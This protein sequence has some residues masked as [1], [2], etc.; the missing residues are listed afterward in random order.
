MLQKK[1]SFNVGYMNV[2]LRLLS[3]QG[4]INQKIISD[5]KNISYNIT[6][7]GLHFFNYFD[8]YNFCID[9]FLECVNNK[10]I[11]HKNI[12]SKHYLLLED[13]LKLSKL[14]W[15]LDKNK[16][17]L[18]WKSFWRSNFNNYDNNLNNIYK[19]PEYSPFKKPLLYDSIK[20]V[21]TPF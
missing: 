1:F 21:K 15:R 20:F 4:L 2:A 19:N 3:S 14:H 17:Y 7:K 12:N 5:G 16:K 6:K 18:G 8:K 9:Y 10:L 11:F 13:L